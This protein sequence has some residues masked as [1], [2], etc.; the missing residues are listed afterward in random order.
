MGRAAELTADFTVNT[1]FA[2]VEADEEQVISHGL[3][4]LSEKRRSSREASIFQFGA[5]QRSIC[6]SHGGLACRRPAPQDCRSTFSAARAC[7]A[8][9][10]ATNV[11]I[12]DLQT[13]SATDSRTGRLLA[14]SNNFGVLRVQRE[15]GR[16]N[17]G[18]IFVNREG[19]GSQAGGDNYNRAYGLDA[20]LQVTRNSK[21]FL[22]AARTDSPDTGPATAP[23]GS[24]HSERVFYN[25]TN[26]LWQVS[27][28]THRWQQLQPRGRVSA[29]ASYRRPESGVLQPQPK[30]WPWIRRISPHVSYMRTTASTTA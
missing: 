10:A 5:P 26:N 15:V 16:S 3:M 2:Q 8:K 22:F 14:P 19:T 29:A 12:L 9:S 24:D 7:Q 25:F 13:D 23:R 30:Q 11:G 6:S 4:C 18:G 21:L 17:F 20:A 28:G 27:G 1:D